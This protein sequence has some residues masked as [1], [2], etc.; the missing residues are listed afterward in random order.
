MML[1]AEEVCFAWKEQGGIFPA[2][3]SFSGL[4]EDNAAHIICGES[5]SGKTTLGLLLSGLKEPDGGKILLNNEPIQ[6]RRHEIAYVFQF[7]ETLFFA[8]SVREEFNDIRGRD[9]SETIEKL[10]LSWGI[11]Y[12]EFAEKHPFHLSA[13]YARLIATALQMARAPRLLIVDEPTIGLDEKHYKTM[14]AAI[15][16]WIK[17]ERILMVITHDLDFMQALGGMTWALS[18]GR[19]IWSGATIDLLEDE[20]RLREFGLKV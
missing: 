5:G 17:P 13:G 3:E 4:F 16:A 7:P 11:S 2:V 6:K 10:L 12:Q 18:A 9:E 14:I 19:L 1:L 8:D 15:K 20:K